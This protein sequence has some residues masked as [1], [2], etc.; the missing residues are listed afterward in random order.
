MENITPFSMDRIF[1]VLDKS[2]TTGDRKFEH[3]FEH[4]KKEFCLAN[5]FSDVELVGVYDNMNSHTK[6]EIKITYSHDKVDDYKAVKNT[7]TRLLDEL[8]FVKKKLKEF[9][10]ESGAI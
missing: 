7:E 8:E 6:F 10:S 3:L 1:R 4:T 5:K 9:E 2:L